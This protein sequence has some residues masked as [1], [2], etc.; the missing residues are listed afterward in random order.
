MR[1]ALGM[2]ITFRAIHTRRRINTEFQRNNQYNPDCPK[3]F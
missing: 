2:K 1:I 3:E